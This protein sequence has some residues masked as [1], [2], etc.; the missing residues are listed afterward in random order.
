MPKFEHL[1]LLSVPWN[2]Q[3][4][5]CLI[6]TVSHLFS[7]IF[8]NCI[9]TSFIIFATMP[10]QLFRTP[11]FCDGTM[12]IVYDKDTFSTDDF[13]GDAEIDIQP[14]VSAA[15]AYEMSTLNESLQQLGKWVAGKD[16]TL[17]EDGIIT[18]VEGKVKQVINLRL[19]NVERGVLEIELE[20]V[21]L[22]Q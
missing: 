21:P 1:K 2:F 8:D 22:T 11:T 5:I 20:C 9:G 14:L 15:R 3:S 18:L 4:K 12:Q 7:E 6:L 13:M 16:N 19:Q 10:Y 17:V